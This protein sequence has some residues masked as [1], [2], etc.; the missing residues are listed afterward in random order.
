MLNTVARDNG[1]KHGLSLVPRAFVSCA[2][3]EKKIPNRSFMKRMC[4]REFPL[5]SNSKKFKNPKQ[6][7]AQRPNF[8]SW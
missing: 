1:P 8:D 4:E 6:C 7:E 5:V 3:K 2:S